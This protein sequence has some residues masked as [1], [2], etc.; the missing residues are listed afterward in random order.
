MKRVWSVMNPW[1]EGKSPRTGLKRDGGTRWASLLAG[2][3]NSS[4]LLAGAKHFLFKIKLTLYQP[5]EKTCD[6]IIYLV[7]IL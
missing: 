1:G 4:Y 5:G 2:D 6:Y 7:N 3:T